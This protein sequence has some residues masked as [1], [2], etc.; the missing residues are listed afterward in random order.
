MITTMSAAYL[1]IVCA[2]ITSTGKFSVQEIFSFNGEKFLC[3]NFFTEKQINEHVARKKSPEKT[4]GNSVEKPG[5]DRLR[6]ISNQLEHSWSKV[7]TINYA[8][9]YPHFLT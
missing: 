9:E 8:T 5:K 4:R 1:R 6:S 7:Q 2:K 3:A